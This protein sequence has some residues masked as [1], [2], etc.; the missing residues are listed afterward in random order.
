MTD[1]KARLNAA[2]EAGSTGTAALDAIIG[3][4]TQQRSKLLLAAI[5]PWSDQS[6]AT[7]PFKPYSREKLEELKASMDLYGLLS[8][9]V[10]RELPRGHY[11]ILSGHNRFAAAKELGW[12]EVDAIILRGVS[13]EEAV[14][15]LVEANLIQRTVIL[16]SERARAWKLKLD[17]MRHQGVATSSHDGTR[18]SDAQLGKE[19]NKGRSTIQR[20]IRL[21]QLIPD[22][23]DVVDGYQFNKDGAWELNP[24]NPLIPLTVAEILA[25]VN[26]DVQRVLADSYLTGDYRKKL[27]KGQAKALAAVTVTEGSDPTPAVWDCLHPAE[28]EEKPCILKLELPSS[29]G[30]YL[31]DAGL[32][33]RLL[34]EVERYGEERRRGERHVWL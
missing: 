22:L 14:G 2:T 23:L 21:T 6:N 3:S 30:E 31:N 1:L 24:K 10:V 25:G 27:T 12:R 18:R 16:P 29:L 20:Y 28:P 15:I 5:E 7:Q 19:E 9:I 4:K 33:Q 8:P 13:D 11:Q 34:R 32:H 26:K 17:S